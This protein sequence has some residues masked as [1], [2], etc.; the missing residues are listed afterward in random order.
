[1]ISSI[2]VSFSMVRAAGAE[3]AFLQFQHNGSNDKKIVCSFF[4]KARRT[5]V[6]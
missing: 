2:L 6:L 5:R 3:P 1:M 4:P